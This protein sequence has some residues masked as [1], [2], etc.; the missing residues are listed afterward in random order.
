M[1]TVNSRPI[2]AIQQVPGKSGLLSKT[3]LKRKQNKKCH[4]TETPLF[5]VDV[6]D[7]GLEG[8]GL[9]QQGRRA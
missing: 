5:Q 4:R 7:A 8:R 9:E 2:L 1:A 3:C 6:Q